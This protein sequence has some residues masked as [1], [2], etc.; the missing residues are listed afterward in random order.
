[1]LSHPSRKNKGAVPRGL[2]GGAPSSRRTTLAGG[3]G[4]GYFAPN[5]TAFQADKP[6]PLVPRPKP[7]RRVRIETQTTMG[8]MNVKN[9][10]PVGKAHLCRS[11]TWGHLMTGYRESDVRVFCTN[12]TPN[13]AVP[14]TMYECTGYSDKN[15][16]D[17]EQMKKLAIDFQPLRISK[18]AGFRGFQKPEPVNREDEEEEEVARV[19]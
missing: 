17:Y 16:P 11:C 12:L 13:I 10:T 15:R 5:E 9:G 19:R 14:F 6:Q 4:Y 2:P 18:T 3:V 7:F 1:M 8:K